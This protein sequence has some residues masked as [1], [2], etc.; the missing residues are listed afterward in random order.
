LSAVSDI[1][2]IGNRLPFGENMENDKMS[3]F[4]DTVHGACVQQAIN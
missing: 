1:K 4:G 3:V 2:K